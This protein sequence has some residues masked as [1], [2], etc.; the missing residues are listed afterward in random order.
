MEPDDLNI[1]STSGGMQ[2][3]EIGY[4]LT[5]RQMYILAPAS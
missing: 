3:E 4:V 1:E 5:P 2:T